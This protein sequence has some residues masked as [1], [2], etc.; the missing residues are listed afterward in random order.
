[1]FS[2]GEFEYIKGLTINM[3]N[4]GYRNY[5]CYTN[6][7]INSYNQS[8]YDVFCYYSKKNITESNYVF[9]IPTNSKKCSFDSK[10]ITSQYK[11]NSL[12]CENYNGS[13]NVDNKEFI[14]SNIENYSNIIGKYEEQKQTTFMITSVLAVV[15]LIYLY[16]FIAS[17][18][19]G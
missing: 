13:I 9:T 17:I 1:M 10:N 18:L 8:Y 12:N 16:K 15:I 6:N 2:T 3:Y 14:Y 5:V 7:P 19:R 4:N 11:L